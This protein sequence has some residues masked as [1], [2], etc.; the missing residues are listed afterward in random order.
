MKQLLLAAALTLG[1]LTAQADTPRLTD[2]V[3]AAEQLRQQTAPKE[4]TVEW[5]TEEELKRWCGCGSRIGGAY[6][7]GRVY[8]NRDLDLDNVSDRAMVVHELIHWLQDHDSAGPKD[9]RGREQEAYALQRSWLAAQGVYKPL[10]WWQSALE[11]STKA[12]AAS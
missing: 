9:C 5:L 11:I 2:L 4:L 10:S 6:T 8:L 7:R 1:T 12:C 3:R